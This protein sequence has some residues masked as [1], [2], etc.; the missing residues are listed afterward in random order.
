MSH[1]IISSEQTGFVAQTCPLL[2]TQENGKYK[3]ESQSISRTLFIFFVHKQHLFTL[4]VIF[5]EMEMN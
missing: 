3:R 2:E 4:Y 1:W 5:L